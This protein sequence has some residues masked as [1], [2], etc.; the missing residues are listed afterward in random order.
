MFRQDHHRLVLSSFGVNVLLEDSINQK[1]PGNHRICLRF[2]A[3]AKF[4]DEFVIGEV[5]QFAEKLVKLNRP[6]YGRLLVLEMCK[7]IAQCERL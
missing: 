3:R 7:A 1:F 4:A 5:R 6:L 2:A